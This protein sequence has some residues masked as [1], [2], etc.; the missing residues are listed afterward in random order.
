MKNSLIKNGLLTPV[1]THVTADSSLLTESQ[2]FDGSDTV[3]VGNG[4][5]LLIHNTGSSIVQ[6]PH[7]AS[8]KLLSQILHCPDASANLLSIN[9]FCKD[10]KCWFAL[11]DIDFTVKDNLTG[12]ILLHGPSE[13]G[14][15]PIRLHSHSLNKTPGS[16]LSLV[17]KPLTWFGISD[18]DTLLSLFYSIYFVINTFPFLVQSISPLCVNAVNLASPNNFR[19]QSPLEVPRVL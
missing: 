19:F 9:K 13:N 6:S 18:W 15:Y 1:P 3:G 2:P 8:S 10:N 17:S 16:L 14:L 7:S 12:K 4:T 11:T 5:G